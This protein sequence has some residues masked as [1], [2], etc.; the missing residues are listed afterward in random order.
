MAVADERSDYSIDLFLTVFFKLHGRESNI[1]LS[2]CYWCFYV[3]LM[4]FK[5][6]SVARGSTLTFCVVFFSCSKWKGTL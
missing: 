5:Q 6:R 3:M 4:G 2:G 1:V